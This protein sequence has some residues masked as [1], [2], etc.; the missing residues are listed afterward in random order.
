MS[1]QDLHILELPIRPDHHADLDYP[2]QSHLSCQRGIFGRR[3]RDGLSVSL[4]LLCKQW[5]ACKAEH[6]PER[7][8]CLL[9]CSY[10]FPHDPFH[11]LVRNKTFHEFQFFDLAN[12]STNRIN[13]RGTLHHRYLFLACCDGKLFVR[14]REKT[15]EGSGNNFGCC[16]APSQ[17]LENGFLRVGKWLVVPPPA[18]SQ[19]IYSFPCS[20]I[21]SS[22][23]GS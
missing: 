11:L 4:R 7:R 18:P 10:R 3:F 12:V 21:C 6:Q 9:S 8:N 15:V 1:S 13:E 23:Q 22:F 14:S 2:G 16:L 19:C 5:C 20:T 17:R